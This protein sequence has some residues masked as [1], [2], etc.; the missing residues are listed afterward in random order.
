MAFEFLGRTFS[1]RAERTFLGKA[2]HICANRNAAMRIQFSIRDL[3][4][5]TA[6]VAVCIG[7][8]RSTTTESELHALF[9]AIIF[10]VI[11]VLAV[12]AGVRLSRILRD[13][14]NHPP[15]GF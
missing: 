9:H 1:F 8:Y 5:L 12:R 2:K 13:L 4:W 15:W 11:L 10:V 6:I 7:W 14:G 3:L